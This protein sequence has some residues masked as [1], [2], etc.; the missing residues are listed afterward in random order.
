[1]ARGK[2]Y[3]A[4]W[5]IPQLA[6]HTTYVEPFAGGLSVLLNKPPAAYEI[7]GDLNAGLMNFYRVLRDRT[8]EL[9]ARL[10]VIP[11]ER[12]VF[13][14]ALRSKPTGDTLKDA[15]VFM[16]RTR[17]SRGGLGKAFAWSDRPR[18]GQPGDVNAWE[19][20]KKKLP[21]VARRLAKVE[22]LTEDAFNLIRRYDGPE[23]SFYLD[24]PYHHSTRTAHNAYEYE[25][26]HEQH[27]KLVELVSQCRGS[28]VLSG[29]ASELYDTTL[30]SW[31]RRRL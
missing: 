1:M 28:V 9:I 25:M 18:G 6:K 12:R 13:E 14:W 26:S 17:F 31:N 19:N 16:V 8:D 15:V 7:V 4:P 10:N 27:V 2:R 30:A 20:I 23:T 22:L 24:P 3:L 21:T 5:I 29:Y 11:Y